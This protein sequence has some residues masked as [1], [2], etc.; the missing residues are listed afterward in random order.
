MFLVDP[1]HVP[2]PLFF[3][4]F[5]VDQL[6]FF[7]GTGNELVYAAVAVAMSAKEE[8]GEEEEDVRVQK[9]SPAPTVVFAAVRTPAGR[10]RDAFRPETIAH[11][12]GIPIPTVVFAAVRALVVGRTRVPSAMAESLALL[13]H[14]NYPSPLSPL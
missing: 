11:W 6:V 1:N 14:P 13:Q 5:V 10:T 7:L 3:D 2:P 12:N 4:R 9:R 8:A